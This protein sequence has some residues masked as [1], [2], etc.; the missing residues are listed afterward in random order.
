MRSF[1]L[2]VPSK[3]LHEDQV[4]MIPRPK[5]LFW[6]I[7]DEH[8]ESAASDAKEVLTNLSE[9]TLEITSINEMTWW[10]PTEIPRLAGSVRGRE[11]DTVVIFSATY[12]TSLCIVDIVKRFKVPTVIWTLP[13]R[14]SLASSGLAASYLKE[15][16]YW[17][18]LLCA[19]PDD[20]TARAEVET[21][22]RAA[23]ALQNSRKTRIGIIGKLSPLMISLPYDLNL[24]EKKLG[25]S[26]VQISI[27]SLDTALQSIT[28]EEVDTAVSGFKEKFSVKVG[29]DILAKAVRFQLAVRKLVSKHKIDGIA[30]E[31]WTRLFPKYG[32]NPCLGHLDDLTIGCEGDVISLSGSLILRSINGVNP[33]LADILGVDSK[34]NTISLSHCSAPTSLARNAEDISL[35]ERT[36][37]GR[38]GKTVFAHFDFADGPVTIVRFYGRELDKIHMTSGQLHSSGEYWGG[39]R[40]DIESNGN[41]GNF[42]KNVCGNHYLLTH[43]DVRPELRL[44]A[45]WNNLE[46]IED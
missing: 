30:L 46:I 45:E 35:V 22:A 5:V 13:T 11:F 21:V 41:A 39:I 33:Y 40:L 7:G 6:P 8:L 20:N 26:T 10:K 31:C 18:R 23:H 24:L 17:I 28:Q 32:V 15:R 14:Y 42:L 36:D 34:T 44:F 16:G 4:R 38:K 27:Q 43:G 3:P 9:S 37:R 12:Y 25:P 19:D 29:G 1:S 2:T